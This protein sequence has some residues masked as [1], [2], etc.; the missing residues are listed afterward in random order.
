MNNQMTAQQKLRVLNHVLFSV[1]GFRNNKAETHNP[2]YNFVDNVFRRK[3]GN[4]MALGMLYLIICRK[5]ELPVHGVIVPGYFIL[6]YLDRDEEFYIDSFNGGLFFLRHD[7][8]RF[9]KEMGVEDKPSYYMPTSNIYTILHLISYMI[10]D[11]TEQGDEERVTEM[12][13]LLKYIEIR[14]DGLLPPD[15]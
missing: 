8:E 13:E 1:D 14:L 11:Y 15:Q 10:K 2:D 6:V 7:L 9:L 12:N 4:P 3:K 5:L